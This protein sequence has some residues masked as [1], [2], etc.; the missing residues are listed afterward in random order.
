MLKATSLIVVLGFIGN[1]HAGTAD[2]CAATALQAAKA[3]AQIN[4][5]K[6]GAM[7]PAVVS[8]IEKIQVSEQCSDSAIYSVSA[9]E[10]ET[11]FS[12]K[13][14]VCDASSLGGNTCDIVSVKTPQ[15]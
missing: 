9:S 11:A 3:I 15:Q 8:N 2:K 7:L 6:G 5:V 12:Y 10:N 1:V 14:E 13:I 4:N